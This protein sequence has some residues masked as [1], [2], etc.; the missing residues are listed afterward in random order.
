M[1]TAIHRLSESWFFKGILLITALSFMTFFGVGGFDE[2]AQKKDA[3]IS[4]GDTK[5]TAAELVSSYNRQMDAVRQALGANYKEDKDLNDRLLAYVM[6]SE[7]E[8]AVLTNMADE[9]KVAV[10]D[11]VLRQAVYSVGDFQ[12]EDGSFNPALFSAYLS[13]VRLTEEQFL[14]DLRKNLLKDNIVGAVAGLS[15]VPQAMAE[16]AYSKMFEKRDLQIKDIPYDSVKI[17]EKPSDE[18][19]QAYYDSEKETAYMNPEYRTLSVIFLPLSDIFGKVPVSDDEITENYNANKSLYVKPELR[20]VDQMRFA[21]EEAADKAVAALD[22]KD[23]RQVARELALQSD[24]D[25]YLGKVAKADVL[26]EVADD[27]FKAKKGGI[28]GPVSS[29]FGWH[30]FK[31]LSVEPEVVTPLASVKEQIKDILQKQKAAESVY[32]EAYKIDDYLGS[33]KT[34]EEAKQQFGLQMIEIPDIDISGKDRKGKQVDIAIKSLELLPQAFSLNEGVESQVMEA[35]NGFYVVRADTVTAPEVKPVSE[36]KDKVTALWLADKRAEQASALASDVLEDFVADK[37]VAA[38]KTLKK[39]SRNDETFNA[40]I[41]QKAF[42]L[43][44]GESDMVTYDGGVAVVKVLAVTPASAGDNQE[45]VADIKQ[46][47]QRVTANAMAQDLIADFAASYEV[48]VNDGLV[49]KLFNNSDEG[50]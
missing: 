18:E 26:A 17:T 27:L 34:L 37:K 49:K 39:V 35:D 31:V 11:A 28:V 9:L 7:T 6:K 19:I 15:Y 48:K 38:A 22:N 2:M 3:V 47:E 43:G 25:T 16:T 1:L 21:T 36:V 12:N 5:V 20:E 42:T 14:A 8:D 41:M 45:Q 33:G 46:S 24:E 29:E 4:V 30:I 23:F 50:L 40:R 10:P 13:A 44:V 32:D